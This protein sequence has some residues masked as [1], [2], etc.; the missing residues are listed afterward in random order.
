MA[1]KI[2]SER[3][4]ILRFFNGV[5]GFSSAE[6]AGELQVLFLLRPSDPR[7]Q[8][9]LPSQIFVALARKPFERCLARIFD[10]ESDITS[11]RPER[12]SMKFGLALSHFA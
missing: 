4:V 3:M 8:F 7:R 5:S 12:F 11:L 6:F 2:S 1:R 10:I 9:E